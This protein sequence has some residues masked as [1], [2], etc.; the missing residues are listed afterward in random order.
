MAVAIIAVGFG[1]D[2][3]GALSLTRPF[4]RF[5]HSTAHL[6]RLHAINHLTRD[7]IGTGTIGHIR[8][9]ASF[10]PGDGHSVHVIFH[11]KHQR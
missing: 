3:A 10:C 7:A 2:K 1:F 8:Q 11:H 6:K 4:N 9:L 5:F